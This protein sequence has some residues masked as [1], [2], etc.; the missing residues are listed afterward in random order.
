MKQQVGRDVVALVNDAPIYLK[1]LDDE[2]L[3]RHG[4][5]VLQGLIGRRMLEIECAQ[6]QVAVTDQE[7][8]AE[9]AR[10][11]SMMMKPLENGSPDVKGWL[12]LAIKQKGVSIETYRHEIIWPSVA[13]KK[14]TG[15]KVEV[16]QEDLMKGF[17]ANYG[18]RVECRAIVLNNLR[19][20]QEVWDAARNPPKELSKEEN[21][22][23]LAAK[24]S[25]ER[26]SR[27]NEGRVPPI[28]RY[29][30]QPILEEEAF[31]LKPGDISGVINVDDKFIIL[32]CVGYTTPIPVDFNTVKKDIEDDIRDKKQRL[33]MAEYYQHMEETTTV[34]NF[35]QPELSRSPKGNAGRQEAGSAVPT[36]YL[37]PAEQK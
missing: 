25:I 35:L 34:D 37:A 9:I 28:R 1:Q 36:N 30:S 20:A 8:D 11:A 13:L 2:C 18:P 21:F 16:T 7:I 32:Y 17:K 12:N 22:A 6:K 15:G 33:A 3:A 26:T 4:P 14:L 29:G 10:M 24:Y 27:A 23:N 19:R 5:D 31:N